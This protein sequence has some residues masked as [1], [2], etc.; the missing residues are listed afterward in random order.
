MYA[1]GSVD[2]LGNLPPQQTCSMPD[3]EMQEVLVGGTAKE[4]YQSQLTGPPS[5]H[6][7]ERTGCPPGR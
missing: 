7:V 1:I 3:G 2:A 5:K 6:G 4:R